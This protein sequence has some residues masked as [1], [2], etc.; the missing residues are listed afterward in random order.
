MGAIRAR[1]TS[2]GAE[3]FGLDGLW[4]MVPLFV[5]VVICAHKTLKLKYV[6]MSQSMHHLMAQF[7][8]NMT[9]AGLYNRIRLTT[10]LRNGDDMLFDAQVVIESRLHEVC[11]CF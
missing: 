6:E 8:G 3:T 2:V 9:A 7:P 11:P 4:I 10:R 1:G 5:L